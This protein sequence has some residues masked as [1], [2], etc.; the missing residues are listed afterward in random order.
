MIFRLD[1]TLCECGPFAAVTITIRP[2]LCL[3]EST[4]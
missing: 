2:H 1:D 4:R 3:P